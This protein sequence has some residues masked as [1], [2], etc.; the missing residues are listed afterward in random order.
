MEPNTA[1]LI[2][3][4]QGQETWSTWDKVEERVEFDASCALNGLAYREN[5]PR[6]QIFVD[7]CQRTHQVNPRAREILQY[8]TRLGTILRSGDVHP[9]RGDCILTV[10]VDGALTPELWQRLKAE[11]QHKKDKA[12]PPEYQ[13]FVARQ[14]ALLSEEKNAMIKMALEMNVQTSRRYGQVL[15]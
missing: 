11:I 13:A 6:L 8:L 3:S 7:L 15:A 2:I 5:T 9:C 10:D 12:P 14:E 4:P 1:V